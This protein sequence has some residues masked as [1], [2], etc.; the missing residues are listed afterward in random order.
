MANLKKQIQE[1]IED[2]QEFAQGFGVQR[3]KLAEILK[4][5]GGSDVYADPKQINYEKLG[6]ANDQFSNKIDNLM[7]QFDEPSLGKMAKKEVDELL[8]K[9]HDHIFSVA[10]G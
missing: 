4:A 5:K 8:K 6:S 9:V 3:E 10:Q 2:C 7:K 1:I